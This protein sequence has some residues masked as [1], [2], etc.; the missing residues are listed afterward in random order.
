MLERLKLLEY[1]RIGWG[2]EGDSM[3]A[4]IGESEGGKCANIA[5]ISRRISN[6]R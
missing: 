6:N 1:C 3:K 2:R 4:A 5:L